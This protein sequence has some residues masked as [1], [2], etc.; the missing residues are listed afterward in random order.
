MPQN[1]RKTGK[2]QYYTPQET[3]ERCLEILESHRASE[4]YLEPA[5]GTGAFVKA[6]LKRGREVISYDIEPRHEAVQRTED[7]LKED[8]LGVLN[9]TAWQF[10]LSVDV[11]G[12]RFGGDR[13]GDYIDE[14]Y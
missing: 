3:A 1:K 4:R 14:Y 7:F 12:K 8:N 9:S 6:L 5:G 2:E 11:F 13:L 10:C